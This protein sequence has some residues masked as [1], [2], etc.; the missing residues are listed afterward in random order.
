MK[1]RGDEFL[2]NKHLNKRYTTDARS[3][4]EEGIE[5]A[6]PDPELMHLLRLGILRC[7]LLLSNFGR[8]AN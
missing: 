3:C 5:Q 4:Y 2:Q 1:R 6:P 7:N 8:V